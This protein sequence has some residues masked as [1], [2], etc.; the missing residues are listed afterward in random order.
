MHFG[1]HI[2]L[3]YFCIWKFILINNFIDHSQRTITE[4][5]KPYSNRKEYIQTDVSVFVHI[6]YML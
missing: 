3:C 6:A 1:A 4:V 5:I 2:K